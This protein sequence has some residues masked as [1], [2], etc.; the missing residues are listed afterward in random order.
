MQFKVNTE[1]LNSAL[2]LGIINANVS[3]FYAPS[4]VALVTLSRTSMKINLQASSIVSEINISG[5]GSEDSIQSIFVDSMKLK[6]LVNSFD[7]NTI[8]FDLNDDGL[9][10]ISGRSKFTLAKMLEGDVQVQKPTKIADASNVIPVVKENWK[11]IDDNQM[12]AKGVS[13]TNKAYTM[14]WCGDKGDVLV[15][16]FDNSLF[17][18]SQKGDMPVTCLLSDTTV[19]LLNSVPE[20][21][22]MVQNGKSFVLDVKT[23][24]YEFTCEFMPGY[25]DDQEYGEYNAS[26]IIDMMSHAEEHIVIDPKKVSKF[27]SQALLLSANDDVVFMTYDNGKLSVT[28]DYVDLPVDIISGSLENFKLKFRIKYLSDVLS[29]YDS[30]ENISMSLVS[31]EDG[32]AGIT[33][34]SSDLTTTLA[35]LD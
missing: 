6:Q 16:D 34:W 11:F 30:E 32:V 24:S 28:G 8:D 14:V 18:H 29:K 26:I 10:L 19:N 4:C 12:Y 5:M 9:T 33:V 15:G 20:G 22:E 13:F 1:P 7:T 25:E 27:L 17:T 23:D 35:G 2:A 21:S 31:N 3:K